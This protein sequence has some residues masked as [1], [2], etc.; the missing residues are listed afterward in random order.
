MSV[1]VF[2]PGTFQEMP[3]ESKITIAKNSATK[4][5]PVSVPD[6]HKQISVHHK[7]KPDIKESDHRTVGELT[8]VTVIAR[9]T[10]TPEQVTHSDARTAIL[11]RVNTA[12]LCCNNKYSRQHR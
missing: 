4:K 9:S 11:T 6:P 10:I 2:S 5:L 12:W 8:S 1:F 7:S 3:R